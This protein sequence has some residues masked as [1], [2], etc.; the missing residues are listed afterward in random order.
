MNDKQPK[1]LSLSA[2]V[3]PNV[4]AT[5]WVCEEIAEQEAEL[6]RLH[7][8]NAEL[9]DALKDIKER[10]MTSFSRLR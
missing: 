6:R 3:R 9:L 8:E 5:P 1:E 4:E 7:A 10:C 2:R